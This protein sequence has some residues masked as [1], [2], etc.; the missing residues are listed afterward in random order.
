MSIKEILNSEIRNKDNIYNIYFHLEGMF[1]RAYEWSAYLSR[2]FPSDL[3][4]SDRLKPLKKSLKDDKGEYVFVGLPMKSIDKYFP[5]VSNNKLFEIQNDNVLVIHAEEFFKKE[6]FSNYKYILD[7]WKSKVKLAK[8]EQNK[9]KNLELENNVNILLESFLKEIAYYPIENKT[10]INSVE[11][12][13]LIRSQSI[14][15]LKGNC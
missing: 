14:K 8:K 4:E 1:W 12:L 9:S 13:S 6:D 11:F 15:F 7:E 10:L 3:S 5:N 2:F